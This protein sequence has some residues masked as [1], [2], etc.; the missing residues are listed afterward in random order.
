M[1]TISFIRSLMEFNRRVLYQGIIHP[2]KNYT[3]EDLKKKM[4]FNNVFMGNMQEVFQRYDTSIIVDDYIEAVGFYTKNVSEIVSNIM[5]TKPNIKISTE[6]SFEKRLVIEKTM[7][8]QVMTQFFPSMDDIRY[9]FING[10]IYY[11]SILGNGYVAI[12]FIDPRR[13]VYHDTLK[14]NFPDYT[15]YWK[16]DDCIKDYIKS[17]Y[18]TIGTIA[19]KVTTSAHDVSEVTK[20]EYNG[21]TEFMK[22]IIN[23]FPQSALVIAN[24]F[25]YINDINRIIDENM[26]H[27]HTVMI[28]RFEAVSLESL[29]EKDLLIE[30]PNDSFD[31]YLQFLSL[32]SKH[33]DVK[34]IYLTLYRIGDNPAI[35]YILRDA[36]RKGIKVHVNIELFASGET[37]NRMWLDEM[38]AEGMHITTYAAGKLKVHSKLTLIKFSNGKFISQVG[39]GNYHTQTTTQ[40]TD[41]ALI[42]SDD[43]ICDDVNNVFKLLD[44]D[45]DVSFSNKLL[46]TRYNAR[47]ILIK[48]IDDEASKGADGYIA[49]K[50]NALDD[51]EISYH[52]DIASE[53]GCQMDLIIRGV[54]TW[55]PRQ[56][57]FNV[58][59]K[60]IVWDKLEHSRVYYFGKENPTIYLG[61]LDLVTKK[62]DQ[63]IEALVKITDPDI[64]IRLCDYLN[65]YVT[66]TIGSWLQTS[67]GLYIKE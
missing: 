45:E 5:I 51:P 37:I 54:C 4:F 46:V 14:C 67:S 66:N 10:E 13:S 9:R 26:D 3:I 53:Q 36:A 40:Y 2:K 19:V 41:F 27:T 30:Y 39:T 31:E 47:K 62:I 18:K 28:P 23:I 29:F 49:I 35:F 34:S 42:T 21:D 50:C 24:P 48:L 11:I 59:V 6:D 60:S 32:A 56:L 17:T 8:D 25:I 22:A 20:V 38:V 43:D 63:R 7:S 16:S 64:G 33:N 52:L 12:S 61:S 15:L 1:Q 57:G 58:K 44:G 55:I 65:R